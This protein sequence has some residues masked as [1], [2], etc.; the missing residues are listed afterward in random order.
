MRRIGFQSGRIGQLKDSVKIVRRNGSN[1]HLSRLNLSLQFPTAVK[2][3]GE[4]IFGESNEKASRGVFAGGLCI[5][6]VTKNLL[7]L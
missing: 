2:I 1:G 3:W 6:P 5:R 4:L 7:L